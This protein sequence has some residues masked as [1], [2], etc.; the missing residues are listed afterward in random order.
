MAL[1]RP[2]TAPCRAAH[3]HLRAPR[4]C[5]G[6]HAFAAA[7]VRS[8]GEADAEADKQAD[9]LA[10]RD[11]EAD[12]ADA[13]A[14]AAEAKLAAADEAAEEAAAAALRAP[15]HLPSRGWPLLAFIILAVLSCVSGYVLGVKL[16][17]RDTVSSWLA[18]VLAACFLAVL[19]C[20]WNFTVLQVRV[21][22]RARTCCL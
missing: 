16:L 8:A 12:K 15:L 5:A 3:F 4:R 7:A 11:R 2:A 9:A 10:D 14:L 22:P 13:A 20:L 19:G 18:S 17:P 6:R 1:V 21:W